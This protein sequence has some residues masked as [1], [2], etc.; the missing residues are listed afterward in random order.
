MSIMSNNI[1]KKYRLY[2]SIILLSL[3]LILSYI[4]AILPFNTSYL[5]VKIGLANIVTLISLHILDIKWTLIIN[6]LRLTLMG[7]I[8]P[9]VIR[10]V[11][12]GSGF[13][14]SYIVMCILLKV[15]GFSIITTSIFGGVSHNVTQIIVVSIIFMD[16]YFIQLMPYYIVFG[17]ISGLVVGLISDL[18]YKKIYKLHLNK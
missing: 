1:I 5:G 17:L 9:N 18:L 11:L 10:F 15:L 12:S 4:E 14:I 7:L 8:F 3:S 16:I 2:Y 6:I 13:F